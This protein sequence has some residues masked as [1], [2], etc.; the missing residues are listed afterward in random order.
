[1]NSNEPHSRIS[2]E[3]GEF[4][5]DTVDQQLYRR[6]ETVALPPK[7][8]DLLAVL[9]DEP[10]RLRS[11]EDLLSKI[12]PDVIVDESNLSQNVFVLRK[13]LEDDGGR[14]IATVPRRGYRFAGAVRVV[15]GTA[16]P[17]TEPTPSHARAGA[18]IES[19][20]TTP[21]SMPV[22]TEASG[23]SESGDEG[24]TFAPR[25]SVSPSRPGTPRGFA[26]GALLVFVIGLALYAVLYA[27]RA[28]ASK[29]EP[30]RSIAVLPFRSL[31]A[32]KGDHLMEL[33]IADT[34][35]N[36]LSQL[37]ELVV[38]PMR[39]V[40]GYA[41][42]P[43]DPLTAGRDL[44]V[45]GVIEG[46]LQRAGPRIRSH[47]R[48]LRVSDGRA[49]WT[50]EYDDDAEDI[51]ALEDRIAERAATALDIRLNVRTRQD[52]ARRYTRDRQ[53]YIL[54][55]QG[56]QAF[57]TFNPVQV[58]ASL[59]FYEEALRRDPRFAL[60]YA[61]IAHSY[62]VMGIYGPLSPAESFARG[63]EAALRCLQIDPDL[64]G[65]HVALGG[66]AMF[67]EWNWPVAAAETERGLALDPNDIDAHTL[68]AY[69][70]EA[71]GRVKEAL[72]DLRRSAELD[73]TWN[74]A[75]NDLILANFMARNYDEAIRMSRERLA[76]APNT[77][78][79]RTFLARSLLAKGD[80]AGARTV[81]E[82]GLKMNAA[83]PRVWAALAAVSVRMGDREKA[84]ECLAR[85]EALK[86]TDPY[87]HLSFVL[88]DIYLAV[89]DRERCF[90]LLNKA[91]DDRDPF[92]FDIRNFPEYDILKS[93]P[94]FAT[95]LARMNLG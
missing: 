4:R 14:W 38:S 76:V 74:I 78:F 67:Y 39:A 84:L 60:A 91:V 62:S 68:H 5:F 51:F 27:P 66:E 61:G 83:A 50:D 34:L 53:A 41:D 7:A 80:V 46:T 1:M 56:R 47:V 35:I 16:L 59:R 89:G 57:M 18:A 2:Y 52:L 44:G 12:W 10:G 13:A 36:K 72:S 40:T 43:P 25:S 11:R 73:P 55:E 86:S 15:S 31:D 87:H 33:G 8:V 75:R 93:D 71:H 92:V 6:G 28:T 82:E 30:I 20:S 21:Q 26:L 69:V 9:L 90:E 64:S 70:L 32:R 24:R 54:Y 37:P 49:E 58:Q 95:I 81:L 22:L 65:C 63:K 23:S 3:F 29:G 77:P 45:D 19:V 42:H 85:V 79:A 48:L 94:R 88:A 17:G